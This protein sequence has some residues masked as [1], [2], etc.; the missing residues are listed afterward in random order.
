MLDVLHKIRLRSKDWTVQERNGD[1]E[2]FVKQVC[3]YE[4]QGFIL[5]LPDLPGYQISSDE[6][7]SDMADARV[8]DRDLILL[9]YFCGWAAARAAQYRKFLVL[10]EKHNNKTQ[11][12]SAHIRFWDPFKFKREIAG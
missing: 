4:E 11:T 7:I 10:D 12:Y 8:N 5:T 9:E 3:S 6:G 1:F 2:R